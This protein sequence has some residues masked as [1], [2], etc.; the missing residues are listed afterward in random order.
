MLLQLKLLHALKGKCESYEN[1]GPGVKRFA[2][3]FYLRF[4]IPAISIFLIQFSFL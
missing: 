1:G 3:A 2:I 4:R